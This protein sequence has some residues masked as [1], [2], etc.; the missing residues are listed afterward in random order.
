MRVL[1]DTNIV[2][3]LML[4]RENFVEDA[5]AI[6]LAQAQ[7]RLSAYI[8]AITPGTAYYVARRTKGSAEARNAVAGVLKITRV[9]TVNQSVLQNAVSLPLADYE[10]AIQL[11]GAL[12][13]QL[14]A[15][16]TRD[17]D[18]FKA[19]PIPVFLPADLLAKVKM[20]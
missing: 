11:A 14:D 9:C 16:V 10:D 1:L 20:N 3:D 17:P 13:E 6:F 12:A 7:G 8:S 5:E 2:L 19:S 4:E 18:D 15:I